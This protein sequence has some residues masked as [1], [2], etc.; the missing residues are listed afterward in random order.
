MQEGG[1]EG[2]VLLPDADD[3]AEDRRELAV[4]G[5]QEMQE[6]KS[7]LLKDVQEGDAAARK[8]VQ[9][10]A[11]DVQRM[12]LV[13]R[14]HGE[15]RDLLLQRNKHLLQPQLAGRKLQHPRRHALCIAEKKKKKKNG[16][17]VVSGEAVG[18]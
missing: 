3:D 18:G 17:M 13:H 1:I 14:R 5:K 4:H 9:Q 6:R 12:Q 8:V 10:I 15:R 11:E 7:G 16:E 2:A